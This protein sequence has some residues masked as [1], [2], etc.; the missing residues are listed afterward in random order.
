VLSVGIPFWTAP[1]S[2]LNV[3]DALY[4]PGLAVV[5]GLALL[6]RAAGI[7]SLARSWNVMAVTVPAAVMAR[8]VVEGS[9]DPT[10]HNL[11]PLVVLI[12]ALVGYFS[13]GPGAGIGH[14]IRRLRHSKGEGAPS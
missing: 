4:G 5:F 6:L 13:A 8:V 11:W 9:L 7:T 10:R 2:T 12:A 1:Y 3:P 14:L